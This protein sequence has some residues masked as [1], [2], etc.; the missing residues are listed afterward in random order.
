MDISFKVDPEIFIGSD[1]LSMAGTI[2]SRYGTRIMIATDK[3][4]DAQSVNRL[5]EILED[6]RLEAIVFDGI[7]EES[8]AEL[9]DN[10]AELSIAA[11]CDAMI[12]FG[13]LKTQI[14]ARMAAI[15][16][17]SH[18]TAFELLDGNNSQNKFLPLL[19][20]PTEGLN[21]FSLTK[22][23]ITTDPRSRM[24]KSTASPE[25]LY[26][27]VIIDTNLYKFLAGSNAA[28]F[29]LEGFFCAI[30]AFCSAK[31]NFFS[32]T[33]LER[34]INY[35]AKLLK[36][37][38]DAINGVNSELFS[39][40]NFLCALGCAASSPG[41][42]AALSTAINARSSAPKPFCSAA[43]FPHIAERL[44]SARPEKMARASAFLSNVKTVS[45][46]EAAA[47]AI[48]NI[49]NIMTALNV[50]FD[51]KSYNISLDRLTAAAENA[52]NLDFVANSPYP[53]A[54][55]D[56]FKILKVIL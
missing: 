54:E 50:P 36:T 46:S 53:V 47:A 20:I 39:Q 7:E 29:V 37:P 49:R 5:K 21:P 25:N 1:T 6:S 52:R 27:A 2:V 19:A 11:H 41:F 10:I 13:G 12:S 31:A 45:T 48:D 51:L 42:G 3:N 35:Y 28:A 34:A 38:I 14:I 8:S 32:D 24:I 18:I 4:T 26:T 22:Y 33:I 43:I 17:P 16:A 56:V 55:E 23:F 44:V 30:E 15:M 9:A 40:A